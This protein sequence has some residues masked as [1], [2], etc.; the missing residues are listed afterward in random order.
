MNNQA[1]TVCPSYKRVLPDGPCAP[2]ESQ[3]DR[4]LI[5]QL[6]ARGLGW[7]LAFNELLGRHRGWLV[8]YCTRRLGNRQDAQDVAQLVLIRAWQA[9]DRFEGRAA[10]RTWLYTIA[11]NQCRTFMKQRMRYLQTEHIERLIELGQADSQR[12]G[13]DDYAVSEAVC[14][15]LDQL[16][17]TAREVLMLRF[18]QDC[19]LEEIAAVLSISLSAA[20]MRL[21]RALDQFKAR[22][23]EL[24][25][26]QPDDAWS[27]VRV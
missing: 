6:Q 11:E 17:D 19:S 1:Q 18:F 5:G 25:G 7:K 23:L 22:Y 20:K 9:I 26:C 15:T 3:S 14:I 24:A 4:E 13:T 10:F 12:V 21:Y 27:T 16:G 8:D 2:V